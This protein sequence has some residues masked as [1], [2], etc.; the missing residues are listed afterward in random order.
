MAR[1]QCKGCDYKPSEYDTLSGYCMECADKRVRGFDKLE[2]ENKRLKDFI[3]C[4][5]DDGAAWVRF[6]EGGAAFVRRVF[7]CLQDIIPGLEQFV[8]E[9]ESEAV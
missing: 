3:L 1:V 5:C 9:I 8:D 7:V 6:D 4:E 2:S